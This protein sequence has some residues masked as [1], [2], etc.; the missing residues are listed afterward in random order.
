MVERFCSRF[1]GGSSESDRSDS[2]VEAGERVCVAPSGRLDGG[3]RDERVDSRDDEVVEGRGMPTG[4]LV[5]DGAGLFSR[6]RRF[7]G[8]AL[9]VSV[10]KAGD[11]ENPSLPRGGL[12]NE[13]AEVE[14]RGERM[15]GVGRQVEASFLLVAGRRGPLV[16]V[17]LAGSRMMRSSSL[18]R[19]APPSARL[20][21]C[22]ASDT[23]P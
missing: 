13:D 15:E 12:E 1:L 4:R 16:G 2:W 11:D 22:M 18:S 3:T 8:V 9:N 23:P 10:I 5:R 20:S 17:V 7:D 21:A 6:L 14:A 19:E